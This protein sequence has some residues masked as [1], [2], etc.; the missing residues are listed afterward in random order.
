[1]MLEKQGCVAQACDGGSNQSS[2]IL[3]FQLEVQEKRLGVVMTSNLLLFSAS[4]SVSLY[5]DEIRF[6]G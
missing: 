3:D 2:V 5:I 4:N 1:M 6:T